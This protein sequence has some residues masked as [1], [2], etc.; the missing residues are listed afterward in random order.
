MY[1]VPKQKYLGP[2]LSQFDQATS[3]RLCIALSQVSYDVSPP[4]TTVCESQ[5]RSTTG[6]AEGPFLSRV[7]TIQTASYNFSVKFVVL[8]LVG[9]TH[10]MLLTIV[11]FAVY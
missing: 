2:Y 7:S 8:V 9:Y 5:T 3:R 6:M 1:V 11:N 4:N 10:F